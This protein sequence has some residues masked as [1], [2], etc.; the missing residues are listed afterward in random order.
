MKLRRAVSLDEY[1]DQDGGAFEGRELRQARRANR[2][3]RREQREQDKIKEYRRDTRGIHKAQEQRQDRRRKGG[4]E[5]EPKAQADPAPEP[6]RFPSMPARPMQ[7][8]AQAQP[9]WPEPMEL[10]PVDMAPPEE[11]AWPEDPVSWEE[12]LPPEDAVYYEEGVAG[13]LSRRPLSV[14]P[15]DPGWGPLVAVGDSLRVQARDGRRAAVILLRP[16]LFLV[17]ELPESQVQSEFGILPILA[18]LMLRAAARSLTQPAAPVAAPPPALPGP[19]VP[20]STE[21]GWADADDVAEVIGCQGRG[22]G[23]RRS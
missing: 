19:V 9:G 11:V 16:G 23:R 15:G 22:R 18:P 2:R 14:D 21:L 13:P 20:T 7:P 1:Q 12:E 3:A 17:A 4:K 6:R 5:R 8:R 10:E